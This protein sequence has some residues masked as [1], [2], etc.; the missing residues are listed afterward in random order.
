[1]NINTGEKQRK[2]C[3]TIILLNNPNP[4]PG[5]DDT[6]GQVQYM[7]FFNDYSDPKFQG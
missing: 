6:H 3:N 5:E 7:S 4:A 1:M 2:L